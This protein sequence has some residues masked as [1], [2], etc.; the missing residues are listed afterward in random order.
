MNEY[1]SKGCLIVNCFSLSHHYES[2]TD[3]I[4]WFSK[5]KAFGIRVY[6]RRISHYPVVHDQVAG[7]SSPFREADV[8][9]QIAGQIVESH[10]SCVIGQSDTTQI[11]ATHPVLDTAEDLLQTG[12]DELFN[13]VIT[14]GS[15]G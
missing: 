15:V 1:C 5:R 9:L 7:Q 11:R 13:Q 2:G 10:D 12:N 6:V 3:E 8:T 14:A 4:P